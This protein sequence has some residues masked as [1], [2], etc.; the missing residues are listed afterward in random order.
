[1]V[2]ARVTIGTGLAK[3]K[4]FSKVIS[5]DLRGSGQGP[6]RKAIRQWGFRYRSFIQERFI[7]FSRGGGN[8]PP[9]SPATI[10]GRRN[11]GGRVSILIDTGAMFASLA[12]T[13][14]GKPGEV[15]EDIPFGIRVGIGGSEIHP[16]AGITMAQL[17][18]IH[19]F[20]EGV[21]PKREIIVP[22]D[23]ATIRGMREDMKRALKELKNSA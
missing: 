8:W 12:P 11:K 21:V 20:G 2:R 18:R 22:P 16:D 7:D 23:N 17:I 6:V 15:N 1:M 13:F 3:L 10:R 4:R 14:M 5:E 19:N 9:L